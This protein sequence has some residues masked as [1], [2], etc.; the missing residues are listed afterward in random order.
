MKKGHRALFAACV[1]ALIASASAFGTT[2]A[3][4]KPYKGKIIKSITIIRKNI[5]DDE[6]MHKPHFYYRW[7]NSVHIRTRESVVR[8][9]LLFH[10]GD[11]LDIVKVIETERNLRLMGFIGEVVTSPKLDGPDGV[12]LTITT[13]DLWTTKIASSLEA[14]GGKYSVGI[15]ATEANILGQGKFAEVSG[16][17]GNDQNGY[18]AIIADPRLFASRF[19]VQADYSH[20]TFDKHYLLHIE[21]PQYSLIVPYALKLD[22]S[23]LSGINRL[24][25]RNK[26]YFRFK[27]E[28]QYHNF[29][30]LYSFGLSTKLSLTGGYTYNRYKFFPEADQDTLLDKQ[31]PANETMS[32]PSLGI[33]GDIIKYAVDR[34]LDKAGT[35]ED[36]TLGATLRFKAGHSTQSFGANFIG[37]SYAALGRF[38]VNPRPNLYFGGIDRIE[39]WNH[40]GRNER[41]KHISEMAVYYKT[42]SA[43]VLTFHALADFAWRQR[44]LYQIILGG[45]NGLRGFPLYEF[46]GTRLAVGNIEYRFYLPIQI[47]TVRLGGA[48]FFDAGNLWQEDQKIYPTHLKS[49]IG[50]GLRLG[51]SKSSIARVL[52]FDVARSLSNNKFFVS[53]GSGNSYSLEFP[54]D[55]Q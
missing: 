35:P 41:I 48:V 24:F 7:A 6:V 30:W 17:V 18:E 40:N 34:Y 13:T 45:G 23:N 21:R 43:Q 19:S 32:Y 52:R 42:A 44:N 26:E 31:I 33:R 46:G 14:A 5:F 54:T 3:E 38:L 29:E 4:L 9:E 11:T 10:V 51:V 39:W 28:N 49:D 50:F 12:D 37:T 1:I 53:L 22:L 25:F 15:D 47:L 36:L 55:I 27:Q 8:R 16:L 20:F 2:D